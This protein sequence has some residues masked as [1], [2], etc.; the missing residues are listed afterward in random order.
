MKKRGKEAIKFFYFLFE[1]HQFWDCRKD[2]EGNAFIM[3]QVFLMN[4]DWWDK[5]LLTG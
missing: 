2:K 5:S 1:K 3:L 4:D